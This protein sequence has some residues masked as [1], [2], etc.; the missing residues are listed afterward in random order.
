M[1]SELLQVETHKNKLS[2]CVA[3]PKYFILSFRYLNST[4]SY[5]NN[6]NRFYKVRIFSYCDSYSTDRDT[7]AWNF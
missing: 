4:T 5:I 7:D 2:N 1:L 3:V 6:F